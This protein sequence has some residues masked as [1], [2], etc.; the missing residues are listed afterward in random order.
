MCTALGETGK[1]L[2]AASEAIEIGKAKNSKYLAH[3][4]IE[5]AKAHL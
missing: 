4:Y 1:A 2:N 3:A 5:E